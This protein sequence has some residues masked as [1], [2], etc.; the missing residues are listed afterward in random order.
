MLKLWLVAPV[1]VAADAVSVYPAPRVLTRMFANVA[2]PLIAATV[3]V[4]DRVPVP[5]L[6]PI[7][8]V[9]LVVAVVTV[10]PRASWI[11]TCTAGVS[12]APTIASLG[13][14][15]KV[16]FAAAPNAVAGPEGLPEHPASATTPS[17]TPAEN[18]LA[19]RRRRLMT[20]DVTLERHP[21]TAGSSGCRARR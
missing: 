15:T 16:S 5:G 21:V 18:P 12:A 8:N 2:T 14:T 19:S 7:P 6:V 10:L 17:T 4:P 9:M 11:A 1:R 20:W 13:C 3:V